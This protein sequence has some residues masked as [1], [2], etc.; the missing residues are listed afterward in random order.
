MLPAAS[1]R[2]ARLRAANGRSSPHMRTALAASATSIV[3]LLLSSPVLARADDATTIKA[4]LAANL[5]LDKQPAGVVVG[6]VDEQGSWIV[7]HGRVN[8]RDM[9]GDTV[10][11]IGSITKT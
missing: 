7:S 9:D 11:E 10:F 1:N 4:F 6:Y 2:A 5:D 3:L 8:G